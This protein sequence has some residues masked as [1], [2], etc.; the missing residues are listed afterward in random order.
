MFVLETLVELEDVI[1]IVCVL[2]TIDVIVNVFNALFVTDIVFAFVE[3]F[4]GVKLFEV[5]GLFDT[6]TDPVT[7]VVLKEVLLEEGHFVLVGE[8]EAVFVNVGVDVS[9]ADAVLVFD[10]LLLDEE[11][12]DSDTRG[13]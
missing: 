3:L 10:G 13:E 11:E 5:D 4:A 7:V 1:V 9:V 6:D 12:E 8:S 2:L